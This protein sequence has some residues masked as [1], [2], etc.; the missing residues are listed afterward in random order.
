[1]NFFDNYS[2][3]RQIS[4]LQSQIDNLVVDMPAGAGETKMNEL[5]NK[6]EYI[7][8]IRDRMKTFKES[9]YYK[10]FSALQ[11]EYDAFYRTTLKSYKHILQQKR[12]FEYN[13]IEKLKYDV[14]NKVI[15]AEKELDQKKYA[16]FE[17]ATQICNKIKD[18]L[19]NLF[20]H[21]F[22]NKKL[23]LLYIEQFEEKIPN[24]TE[25]IK[26][27]QSN[28]MFIATSKGIT[29]EIANSIAEDVIKT[30]QICSAYDFSSEFVIE[31]NGLHN[32]FLNIMSEIKKLSEQVEILED[33]YWK[34][35]FQCTTYKR[36]LEN[37]K[38][39]WTKYMN[40]MIELYF[41]EENPGLYH[42][43]R[44][45]KTFYAST[46]IYCPN[47][48]QLLEIQETYMLNI[49]DHSYGLCG[50]NEMYPCNCPAYKCKKMFL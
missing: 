29:E 3:D 48:L 45:F 47:C 8:N 25:F 46:G 9:S 36:E 1:M 33:Q 41:K 19:K 50:C 15:K 10:E 37:T 11:K 22:T 49:N 39:Q 30:T 31:I 17:I 7:T 38:E 35:V 13:E 27:Y 14:H 23:L 18:V 12:E 43:L 42:K 16:R 32:T 28:S 5:K 20:D 44:E 24:K 4:W 21:I 26:L 34:L 6:L 40:E 2:I